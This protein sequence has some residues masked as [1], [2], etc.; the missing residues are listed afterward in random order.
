M[1]GL[2]DMDRSTAM[3]LLMAGGQ[4]MNT[5][6]NQGGFGAIGNGLL[7]FAQG[8]LDQQKQEKDDARQALQDA[9]QA[10]LDESNLAL[11]QAQAQHYLTS[12]ASGGVGGGTLHGSN[13]GFVYRDPKTGQLVVGQTAD[14][15]T[16]LPLGADTELQYNNAR[17]V[18]A[19]KTTTIPN[20]E[21]GEP[22]SGTVGGF[23]GG[24]PPTQSAP[25]QNSPLPQKVLQDG[26]Y[27]DFADYIGAAQQF[28]P[29]VMQVESG[30]NPNA[31]SET[32]AQG[33]MQV[34]PSTGRDP[35]YNV[36]PLQNKS[37]EENTRF[38]TDYLAAM[39][40]KNNGNVPDALRDYNGNSDPQYV[41]KVM[42]ASP[43]DKVIAASKALATNAQQG[44]QAAVNAGADPTMAKGLIHESLQAG[45]DN[46]AS[47]TPVYKG[48]NLND[49]L[50]IETN[51]KR[52]QEEQA[53]KIKL[54]NVAPTKAQEAIGE[55]QGGAVAANI[56]GVSAADKM[57]Q[58]LKD[59]YQYIYPDGKP[60][61]NENGDLVPPQKSMLLGNSPLDR[62][63]MTGHANGFHSDKAS[64]LMGVKRGFKGLVMSALD[65]KLGAGTSN[66][67][68][69]FLQNRY[70]LMD[71]PEN[72]YKSVQDT[73][74]I[75]QAINDG[76]RYAK[77][78]RARGGNGQ[79][80][81][82]PQA[83]ANA[84]QQSATKQPSISNW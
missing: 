73:S 75:Y 62:F 17:A 61:F 16:P 70:G 45:A 1:A 33:L 32:N 28:V 30:G 34:I 54:E 58:S 56:K 80:V 37:P 67:D 74:E 68:V 76:I 36:I 18:N 39:L 15:K 44:Y 55:A 23:Y 64:N 22:I 84:P 35:G 65:N 81:S 51:A 19:P 60:V 12:D 41:N 69:A 77:Q 63:Q 4:M 46:F 50:R 82:M 26:Q 72:P 27:H 83:Q 79:A 6:R 57:E 24:I 25:Q 14:G 49:K 20:P 9:R 7:G 42:N 48:L 13:M 31:V 78:M 3:G 29:S 47:G 59:M 43:N 10:R 40:K 52:Q 38:G 11:Q 53:A 21:G 2:L 66:A 71:D 8:M 5:P